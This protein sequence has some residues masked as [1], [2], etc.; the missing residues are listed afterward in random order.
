MK[1]KILLLLVISFGSISS[2]NIKRRGG[3]GVG[4]YNTISD[5]LYTALKLT[6][7]EGALVKFVVPQS[8]AHSLKIQANDFVVACNDKIIHSTAELI[9][10]ARFLSAEEPIKI[11][12]LRNNKP[13]EL[14]GKVI[15]K[16]LEKSDVLDITY[17]EF[18]YENGYI[19]TIYK[20]AK[21]KKP[22]GTVYFIHGISCY[23]LDNMQ[24]NDITKKAFDAMIER[25]FAV[26]CIE[27]LGLG[28]S[29]NGIPC[30]QI[31]YNKELDVF[32]EGYKNLMKM[33]DIDTTQIFVF[34]HSLGGISAPIIAEEFN[35]KGV[36][37]Y[38]TGLKPWSD[39]LLDAYLIQSRYYGIDLA[40]L[41]D[42]VELMKPAFYEYFYNHKSIDELSKKPE[43]LRALQM[44][45]GYDPITKM[46]LAGR[47]PQFHRELNEHNLAKSWKNTKSY[48]LSVYGESDI[49]ANNSLDHE[50]IVE[51]VN[52]VHPNK[53]TYLMMPKTNH[54]FQ[55]IGTMAD[56]IKMQENPMEYEKY[57]SQHF[58]T[59][60][61]DEV[62]NWM[63]DKLNKK[64]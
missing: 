43:Y 9:L 64:L 6:T 39:Y 18:K 48:V 10:M 63:K 31:G 26:Y 45:L 35:P 49:A 2:Q 20:K 19:R 61:F 29:Y 32:R 25:G 57:A 51:Y 50:A 21:N 58:N 59:K 15:G 27:K 5:S 42:S 22:L 24:A 60:L 52:Q 14:T 1:C 46:A 13:L 56:Y 33:K 36:V 53:A 30:D 23:S 16:P 62:C 8:T 38:G 54:T 12:V 4:L 28:D 17:G 11:K 41:R 7:R 34:G 47:T 55:E 3:L 40:E 37:V 44:G